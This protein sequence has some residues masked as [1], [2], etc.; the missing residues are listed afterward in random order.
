MSTN[1]LQQIKP[2]S[3]FESR[4]VETLSNGENVLNYVSSPSANLDFPNYLITGNL[5][6]TTATTAA[7]AKSNKNLSNQYEYL[8]LSNKLSSASQP[9]DDLIEFRLNGSTPFSKFLD[10]ATSQSTLST[11]LIGQQQQI[12]QTPSTVGTSTTTTSESSLNGDNSMPELY[13]P[14]AS[15]ANSIVQQQK[16]LHHKLNAAATQTTPK[17]MPLNNGSSS[18]QSAPEHYSSSNSNS[19]NRLR[20]INH[21][22]SKLPPYPPPKQP[23]ILG[24]P[25]GFR[26]PMATSNTL[27]PTNNMLPSGMLNGVSTPPLNSGT[28]GAPYLNPSSLSN[29]VTNSGSG[30]NANINLASIV[31]SLSS[32]NNIHQPSGFGG[33]SLSANGFPYPTAN[34]IGPPS[35]FASSGYPPNGVMISPNLSPEV[36]AEIENGLATA[37]HSFSRRP[38]VNITRVERKSIKN[39]FSFFPD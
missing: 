8:D 26:N 14:I 5:N 31:N 4:I 10:K 9:I 13:A 18:N 1:K 7:A 30:T 2:N 36:E 38:G 32:P 37:T 3:T 17:N 15:F 6:S 34:I 20:W 29:I 19:E 22:R 16:H 11:P 25:S 33:S 12:T 24:L 23:A 21:N 39:T 27:P 35:I 28:N